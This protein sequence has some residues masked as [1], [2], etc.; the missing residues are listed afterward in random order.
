MHKTLYLYAINHRPTD[1]VS[2]YEVINTETWN[3][4]PSS[5]C[6]LIPHEHSTTGT[7]YAQN[8]LIQCS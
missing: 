3:K 5:I 4:E 1:Y 7:I 2:R 8:T 6:M